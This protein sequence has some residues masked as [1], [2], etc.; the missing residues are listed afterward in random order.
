M[1]VDFKYGSGRI[2][3]DLPAERVLA[4]CQAD[5]LPG[6]PNLRAEIEAALANPIGTFPLKSLAAGKQTAAV[7]VDDISR[8]VPYPDVLTPVL[9]QLIEAGVPQEGITAI[10]ATGLHRAMT[11][12]EL[13]AWIGPY[14]GLVR[15]INH[16]PD[17]RSQLVRIGF[18]SLGTHIRINRTFAEAELKVLTGDVDYHQF[19][20]YGGG[21]KSVYPGLADHAAIETNHSRMEIP[22]TGMGRIEGNPVRLEIEEAGRMAGVDFILNVVQNSRKE[23]V[24]AFAGD[25]IEAHRAGAKL[26]DRMYKVCV[27]ERADVV[28]ASPGGYPK[29]IDLYQSQKALS[30]ARRMVKD[31]GKI[32]I[33]AECREGHGSNLFDRW[34]REAQSPEDIFRRIRERFVMGG[35]KAYQYVRDMEGVEVYLHSSIPADQIEHYWLKPL[36]S[37]QEILS[38]IGPDETIICLP[39]AALTCVDLTS[40]E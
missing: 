15:I 3:L 14:H 1:K 33:L 13:D 20:G 23:V 31:G 11:Q 10:V 18:T 7:V 37:P 32:V 17:D 34:M 28:I 19:C 21:A 24:G 27:P 4:V 25:M 26:I 40:K 30:A 38:K 35:H 36:D 6:V 16:Q 39:D 2:S 22:G 29:D 5:D 12:E 9:D 8:P